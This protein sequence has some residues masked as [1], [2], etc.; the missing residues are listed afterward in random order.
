MQT[1]LPL[2][3]DARAL[4]RDIT[5][6]VRVADIS[7]QLRQG[8]VLGLLGL[9]GAGKSTTLK[10]LAGL[11]VPDNGH[12]NIH[13]Q[14]LSEQPNFARAQLGYL[15]DTP[16]LYP[17]MKVTAYLKLAAQLRRVP[18]K[19]LRTSIDYALT[20]CDLNNVASS[21]ISSLSKGFRQRVGLAQAI[22]H[23]P[24]L[25][26]LDE[27]NNGLDPHQMHSMRR[28]IKTLGEEAAVIFSTHLLPEA[29]AVCNQ[30]AVMH[31]GRIVA[32]EYAADHGSND[33]E[34]AQA[35]SAPAMF[36]RDELDT[37]FANLVQYGTPKAPLHPA[38]NN[39]VSPYP[40]SNSNTRDTLDA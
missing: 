24:K 34:P 33:A 31:Q 3:L 27:P 1:D 2:L 32:R 23:R 10:M 4:M 11:L 25:I 22:V 39:A 28:L 40:N 13:G 36:N 15:P 30:I 21:R 8:D 19:Q 7:L 17:D 35:H 9:N 12:I 20:V 29:V 37:L 16:P 6:S 18:K 5:P 38:D 26:L 14:S